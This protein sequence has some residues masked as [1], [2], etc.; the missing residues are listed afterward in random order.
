MHVWFQDVAARGE[1]VVAVYVPIQ[2]P[3]TG[4]TSRVTLLTF[5]LEV[6]S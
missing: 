3:V 2:Q 5:H 1:D 6:L 4:I